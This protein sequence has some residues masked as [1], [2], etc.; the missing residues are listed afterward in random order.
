[1]RAISGSGESRGPRRPRARGGRLP[2]LGGL[3]TIF[4][5]YGCG[6]AGLLHGIGSFWAELLTA[7]VLVAIAVVFAPRRRRSGTRDLG[8]RPADARTAAGWVVLALAAS[9]GFAAAYAALG[10]PVAH[11]HAAG[12]HLTAIASLVLSTVV[13]A[14][15]SEEMA[16]R[17]FLYGALRRSLPILPA[18]AVGAVVF[19]VIHVVGGDPLASAAPRAVDGFLLC[20]LYERTGSI[21]PG[22]AMHAFHNALWVDVAASGNDYATWIVGA[23]VALLFVAAPWRGVRVPT[24]A[25][26][27][28]WP[29]PDIAAAE[30]DGLAARP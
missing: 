13:L 16:F 25:R 8:L 1:M 14:P 3:A 4:A 18:A 17:G 27:G 23:V 2:L 11:V 15:I 10:G 28:R 19:G 20:L 21:V 5:V 6:R 30:P 26:A 12:W 7:A 22:I 9:T 24:R 29:R